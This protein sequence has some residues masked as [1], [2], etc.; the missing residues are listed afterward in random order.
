[1]S[2]LPRG[3]VTLLFTDIEGSTRL[4][5]TLGPRY[6]DA[7]EVHRTILRAAFSDHHQGTEVDTQGDAFF[8]AFATPQDALTAATQAQRALTNH[9]W[10]DGAELRVRM[11]I[12]TGTP[13]VTDQGYVG[14]DV[15]LGARIC[16][17]AWGGQILVSP[18]TAAHLSSRTEDLALRPLGA[19]TLKDLDD[20]VELSQVTAPGLRADFPPPR[21]PSSSHLT[22][23]PPRLPPLIGRDTDLAALTELLTTQEV[24]L[25]TL[26]G[27]GGTGKTRLALATGQQLLHS[28]SDGVFF[29]DL[30][31]LTD[32]DLVIPHIAATLSLRESPGRSLQ[33]TLRD[34]LS[35]KEMLLIT[36]NLEQVID[37][38][39]D[40][41]TLVTDAPQ[42][43]VLVTSREALRVTGERVYSLSPLQVPDEDQRDL[44]QLQRSP[45]VALFTERARQIKAD[46]CLTQDN[47]SDVGAICRR[48]DGLPLA[49]EL[50]AARANLLSPS[51]LLSRLDRGLK[52]LSS[53]RRDAAQRQRTLRAAIAWSYDLL[54]ADE[55]RLFRRLGVFVGGFGLEAAEQ[56]CDRGDLD[57]DVLDGLASLV[58]KSLVRTVEGEDDRFSMLETIRE[59]AAD[60][61][62]ECGEAEEIR[63]AHA[64]FFRALAEEAEPHLVEA[65]HKEWLDRLERDHDNFRAA[66]GSTPQN[67]RDVA[68]ALAAALRRFWD[69]R[70]HVTEGRRWLDEILS[71]QIEDSSLKARAQY[72]AGVL[73]EEQGDLDEARRLI[74]AA[75]ALFSRHDD[76]RN[77]VSCLMELGRIS[78]LR[79]DVATARASSEDA[80]NLAREVGDHGLLARAL[81]T[82]GER[83]MEASRLGEAR[84]LYEEALALMRAVGDNDGTLWVTTN[85]GELELHVGDYRRAE[86]HLEK[87]VSLAE[88]AGNLTGRATA[89]VNLG[90]V[91]I[92]E[93]D[94]VTAAEHLHQALE[95]ASRVGV[96]YLLAGCLE[97]LAIAAIMEDR[98]D[99]GARLFG[100]A[101]RVR[102]EAGLHDLPSERSLYEAH[103]G[104]ATTALGEDRWL[105]GVAQGKTMAVEDVATGKSST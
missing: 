95:V 56:V 7:L 2:E 33:E 104:A 66:L 76:R 89:L 59:F 13:E 73:A 24:S 48:L 21:T 65:A 5:H 101:E 27:P 103:I 63:R 53:G 41:A 99:M 105:A 25:V 77:V 37:A 9:P 92:L 47:A 70:G 11:G 6:R 61:L 49:I 15:H 91:A 72:G 22:N 14:Q 69:I 23:L 44:E 1:M 3:T 19:H 38:A 64:E 83:E 85:L 31:A 88:T 98:L 93:D 54:P 36:D 67:E 20:P 43:K 60:K 45:A 42:L 12:H 51:A 57:T 29:T 94:P 50:A 34:H 102:Q 35:P 62:L 30:S 87:A 82:I 71:R 32:A 39:K 58:D 78:W 52:V 74:D 81:V 80:V 18:T 46:F 4:L 97:C 79:G 75:L 10:P 100:T 96:P 40:I 8:Y 26:V 28:F 17:A 90:L 84:A 68:L 55:Q 16:A 86:E